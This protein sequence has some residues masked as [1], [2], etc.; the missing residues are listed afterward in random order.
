MPNQ[1]DPPYR[2]GYTAELQA[3]CVEQFKKNERPMSEIFDSAMLNFYKDNVDFDAFVGIDMVPENHHMFKYGSPWGSKLDT[4]SIPPKTMKGSVCELELED[5]SYWTVNRI[6]PFKTH[7]GYDWTQM[8]W[9]NLWDLR[10]K[11]QKYPEGIYVLDQFSSPVTADGTRLGNP[12]IHVHHIHIGPTPGVRQRG[13]FINCLLN[14]H[15]CYDPT[16]VL[17]H[18]GDYECT[19]DKDGLG[20]D[21]V[22][23]SIP[24]GYGKL[25]TFELGL[26]GDLNDVRPAGSPEFEWYYEL[27]GRWVP[28]HDPSGKEHPK[29]KAVSFHNFA[30]PGEF[31]P[32][33][34]STYIF[35]F[36]TP[37]AE[38][39]IFWYSGRMH[40]TARMLRNKQHAHNAV[41]DEAIFFSATP[42]EL[43][44]TKENGL[45]PEHPSKVIRTSTTGFANNA[46]V[47]KFVM[48]NLKESASKPYKYV[49]RRASDSSRQLGLGDLHEYGKMHH[50]DSSSG[51]DYEDDYPGRKGRAPRAI[52]HAINYVEYA[53]DGYGYDRKE[54]TCCV[55]WEFDKGE[56]FTVLAFNSR[57]KDR[58]KKEAPE[59]FPGHIGWWISFD[60]R[61][62]PE[63]SHFSITQYTNNPNHQFDA[64]SLRQM[65]NRVYILLNRGTPDLDSVWLW[66]VG[67]VLIFFARHIL[68]FI[69]LGTACLAGVVITY[70]RIK[71]RARR[72]RMREKLCNLEVIT[73]PSMNSHEL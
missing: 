47:L 64:S 14:D 59:Y 68:A 7:G 25:I 70:M 10:N 50:D 3:A 36:K 48:N 21:C 43:G 61:E 35:T 38:E 29:A 67:K 2:K 39:S 33:V 27:G 4:S 11:L 57:L 55:D 40:H 45:Y 24:Q 16:R 17:E 19:R 26:E 20:M 42:E 32:G 28:K 49:H 8:G 46:A 6:G 54:P 72:R 58:M 31:T 62:T 73:G 34:Q 23:E 5:G 18:H 44:L 15:S 30:G 12:P 9:D 51:G 52:C 37:T 56:V 71:D 53:E 63:Q 1:K 13:E 65:D 69:I 66:A 60:T 22:T 41:Y